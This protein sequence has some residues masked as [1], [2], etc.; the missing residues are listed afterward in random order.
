MPPMPPPAM[1]TGWVGG[2]SV[3][4]G[5]F[6]EGCGTALVAELWQHS[7]LQRNQ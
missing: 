5:I 3:M 7:Q 6:P 4:R 1:R 2:V